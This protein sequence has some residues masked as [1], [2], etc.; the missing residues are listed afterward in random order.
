MQPCLAGAVGFAVS[1][2][3]Y[4][5]TL[6]AGGGRFVTLTTEAVTLASGGD[7]RASSW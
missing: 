1:A 3:L 6:F 5:P 7:R 4:L 2:G